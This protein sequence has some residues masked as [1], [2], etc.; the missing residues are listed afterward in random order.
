MGSLE[1][2]S[3]QWALCW[4]GAPVTQSLRSSLPL[5]VT[6]ISPIEAVVGAPFC[7]PHVPL[8][9]VC[10]LLPAWPKDC[11]AFMVHSGSGGF[12]TLP[13]MPRPESI[14]KM[15]LPAPLSSIGP[16]SVFYYI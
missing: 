14:W 4:A 7:H 8:S 6:L 1:W 15:K 2:T 11:R 5:T 10:W 9:L 13:Q 12:R 3:I 16:H